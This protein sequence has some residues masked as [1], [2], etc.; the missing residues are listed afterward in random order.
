MKNNLTGFVATTVA[1]AAIAIAVTVLLGYR[2]HVETVWNS[3]MLGAIVAAPATLITL[4]FGGVRNIGAHV[5]VTGLLSGALH[6]G[7]L[8]EAPDG[9]WALALVTASYGIGAA[10]VGSTVVRAIYPSTK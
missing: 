6:I 4:A 1:W 10:A 3:L 8:L 7:M 2:F 5:L 9:S